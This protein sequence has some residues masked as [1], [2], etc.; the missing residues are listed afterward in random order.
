MKSP[1]QFRVS[2]PRF[3]G[4]QDGPPERE[5]KSR[6]IELFEQ[7]HGI[8]KAYLA[9]VAYDD[10]EA[11]SVALCLRAETTHRDIVEKIGK[12]FGSMFPSRERLDIIFVTEKQECDLVRSCKPFFDSGALS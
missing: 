5:L 11:I 7:V 3:I 2:A 8:G 6:L 1:E 4:E 10:S 12:I 9:R